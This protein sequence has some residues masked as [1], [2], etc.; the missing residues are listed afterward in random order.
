MKLGNRV[1][2]LPGV[3]V[4]QG[5]DRSRFVGMRGEVVQIGKDGPCTCPPGCEDMVLVD[6]QIVGGKPVGACNMR[7]WFRLDELEIG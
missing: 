4:H 1:T 6:D 2:V 7:E 3:S 5:A